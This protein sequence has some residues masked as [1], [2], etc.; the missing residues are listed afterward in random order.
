MPVMIWGML[1]LGKR[2]GIKDFALAVLITAGCTL[3]L[4]TGE[5]KSKVSSSLF[6]SSVWGLALMLGR[7]G[8][9]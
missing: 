1:I 5:V 8:Q 6:D 4:L 9:V 3:F 2:Y 7:C